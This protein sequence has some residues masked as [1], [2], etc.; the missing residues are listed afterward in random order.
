MLFRAAYLF[1]RIEEHDIRPKQVVA[2]ARPPP[3]QAGSR[4]RLSWSCIDRDCDWRALR[5]VHSSRRC[6][7][8]PMTHQ[9]G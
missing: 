5:L 1:S 3:C 8:G 4:R 2:I 6:L 9:G 7:E